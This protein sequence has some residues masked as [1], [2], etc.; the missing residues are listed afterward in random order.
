MGPVARVPGVC[1][2]SPVRLHTPRITL[3]SASL[4]AMSTGVGA[5]D[6]VGGTMN[7][8][9]WTDGVEVVVSGSQLLGDVPEERELCFRS[10]GES[11]TVLRCFRHDSPQIRAWNNDSIVFAPP[12]TIPPLGQLEV[13]VARSDLA[14]SATACRTVIRRETV[15]IG[16]YEAAPKIHAILDSERGEGAMDITAGRKYEIKGTFFGSERFV[17][18]F[19]DTSL[20]ETDVLGWF[21]TSIIIRPSWNL[22][23]A[24]PISVSN[25]PRRSENFVLRP[26]IVLP[27]DPAARLQWHL[28]DLDV[29]RTWQHSTGRGIL[30]AVIDS[31][32]NTNSEE[33]LGRIWRNPEEVR[34]NGLDDDGNGYVDDVNGWN[35]A[36]NSPELTPVDA[37]GTRMAGLI[38]AAKDNGVGIA[39]VAPDA[40]ILPLIIADEYGG[41]RS[42]HVCAAIR[43]AADNGAKIINL[44]LSGPGLT[45]DFD[46]SYTAC[47]RYAAERDVLTVIGAGNGDAYGLKTGEAHGAY[48][49]QNP[50]S[51]VCN[52]DDPRWSLG[53]VAIDDTYRRAVFSDY[54][55]CTDVSA[56]GKNVVTTAYYPTSSAESYDI[57]SG[58]SPAAALV[59]GVAALT[60][61][62][63]PTLAAWQVRDILMQTATELDDGS[64]RPLVN[65]YRAVLTAVI[66]DPRPKLA[67]SDGRPAAPSL[68]KDVP[69]IHSYY[70][71]IS[72]AKTAGV[73]S[74]Y[75]DGTF[76]PDRV[77]NRAELLKIVL[78]ADGAPV[79]HDSGPTGFRDVPDNAWYA[80]YVRYARGIGM[81]EG[82]GDGTFR[83]E[84]AVNTAEALKMGYFALR[85]PTADVS[86][87]WYE[88]YAQHARLYN[89]LFSSDLKLDS[90][91]TRKDA[92][93]MTWK[94][95]YWP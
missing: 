36:A 37:H 39:G 29:L 62:M 50:K 45:T 12:P 52:R 21:E 40:E 23:A 74:G 66:T 16:L 17:V 78:T 4:L 83:P 76:G 77:V 69:A 70:D 54:G 59:T 5:Q 94:L 56:P 72:W 86:G 75:P 27:S 92:V 24:S 14:C 44:S 22:D 47:I 18:Y 93:W 13:S 67:P 88:R 57:V 3:L 11:D 10:L 84:R 7:T 79:V 68:F 2:D 38:A 41:I 90:P 20:P 48:L 19:G 9:Q 1:D 43:Y 42:D 31:G 51:P 46:P 61:S 30:V 65:A 15:D 95:L 82:Y 81:I 8:D 49:D 53:V 63:K 34:G 55:S 71:A 6:T 80:P 32:V 25:G 33:Y 85:I 89:I 60:W 28:Q 58:T 35:F 64:A 26:E 87:P 73:V 91:M